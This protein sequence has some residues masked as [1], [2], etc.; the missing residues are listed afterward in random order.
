MDPYDEQFAHLEYK[1]ARILFRPGINRDGYWK[2]MNMVKQLR[3]RAIPIFE[4]LHGYDC[5]GKSRIAVA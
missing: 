3:E 5:I 2:S 1:E 4:A